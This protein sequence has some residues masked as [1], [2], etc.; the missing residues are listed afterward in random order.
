[1]FDQ[2]VVIGWL[3]PVAGNLILPNK[4]KGLPVIIMMANKMKKVKGQEGNENKINK[5]EKM[6]MMNT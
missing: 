2:Q 6:M 5:E 3:M 4:P 1:M